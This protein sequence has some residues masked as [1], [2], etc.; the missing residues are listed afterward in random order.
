M[1]AP[2]P[3]TLVAELTYRCPLRCAYCSNPLDW[4]RRPDALDADA[5]CTVLREAEA[6]GVVQVHLTGG[7]PLVRPDL[8]AIVAGAHRLDLY[9]HLV[10]SGIPLTRARLA[11]LRDSGLDAVQ[12]SLQDVVPEPAARIAGRAVLDRKLDAARW[13]KDLDLPLTLNV[14][15]HRDN[16]ARVGDIIALAESLDADKL[17][18]ANTQYLGWA[19]ANRDAL[20]PSR[21]A[22][23]RARGIAAEARRRLAGRMD[24]VFVVP[25]YWADRPKPCMDGWGRTHLVVSPDGLALP[26]QAAHTIP[27]LRFERVRERPLA[28]IWFD[29]PGFRAFRGDAWMRDPCRSCPERARDFGGCRCQAFHLAGD[30][31]IADPACALSPAHG[32]VV[33]ARALAERPG[34]ASL[35]HRTAER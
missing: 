29:S 31:T 25:D 14:V 26:C 32:A 19:L 22:L 7:E 5:W 13:V 9:T 21:A 30:A 4:V 27:G 24:V 2:R 35:R 10:T 33:A 3:W 20:L 8:E 23:A 28:E 6:L 34:A 15:L 12:L 11:A 16:I 18:L 1:S 17:E